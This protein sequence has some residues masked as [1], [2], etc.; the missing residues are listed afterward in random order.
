MKRFAVTY[1]VEHT[2][3][4]WVNDE[5]QIHSILNEYNK[6]KVLKITEL[7]GDFSGENVS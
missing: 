3:E 1:T 4:F 7:P 6:C 2:K 5:S